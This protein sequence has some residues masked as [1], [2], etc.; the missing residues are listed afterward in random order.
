MVSVPLRFEGSIV[1]LINPEQ[2]QGIAD[3]MRRACQLDLQ[4]GQRRLGGQLANQL[5]FGVRERG[6]DVYVN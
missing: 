1:D 4:N 3:G 5:E 6:H 2:G